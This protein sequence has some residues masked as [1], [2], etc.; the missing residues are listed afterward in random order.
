MQ[1]DFAHPTSIM[2]H[3]THLISHGQAGIVAG[4]CVRLTFVTNKLGATTHSTATEKQNACK[5]A[6]ADLFRAPHK[7]QGAQDSPN[8]PSTSGNVRKRSRPTRY[9]CHL[10][11]TGSA[12]QRFLVQQ[13]NKT[14]VR[15]RLQTD[16]AHRTSIKAHITHLICHRRAGMFAGGRVQLTFVTNRRD[17]TTVSTAT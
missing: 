15:K 16:F 4:G 11:L 12:P 13:S 1:N 9:D 14:R 3:I 8:K 7:H 5:K 17:A 2:A 10:S 6:L